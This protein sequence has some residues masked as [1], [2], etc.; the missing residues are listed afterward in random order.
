MKENNEIIALKNEINMLKKM[1]SMAANLNGM[2]NVAKSIK[3]TDFYENWLNQHKKSIASN[4]FYEYKRVYENHIKPYFE[5]IDLDLTEITHEEIQYYYKFKLANGMTTNTLLKHHANLFSAFKY[6][7]K[8]DLITFNPMDKVVRPK[9]EDP[10]FEVFSIEQILN[11]LE[12]IKDHKL[13]TP[14]IIASFLGLRRSEVVGLKWSAVNFYNSTITINRKAI[15]NKETHEIEFSKKM[16]T[17]KSRRVLIL[18]EFLSDYLKNKKDS[19][20]NSIKTKKDYNTK[21]KDFI[22]V[23]NSG[24]LITPDM[25]SRGFKDVL[26]QNSLEHIRFHDL[27]H[28]CATILLSLG[29]DLKHIQEYLGHSSYN[30]TANIYAHV[31]LEDKKKIALRLDDILKINFNSHNSNKI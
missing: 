4:T 10:E 14:I 23:D 30:T 18:P 16:K 27:R 2:N 26:S 19:I 29:F 21:Y 20:T 25:I 3:F 28:S 9:K 7:R 12:C 8:N 11:L 13:F 22:C 15:K 6:A 1:L 24:N 31:V 17:K 5:E